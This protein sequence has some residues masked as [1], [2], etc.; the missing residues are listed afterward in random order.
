MKRTIIV[1]TALLTSFSAIKAQEFRI[2]A[3]A[4]ID[5]A[6]LSISGASGGPLKTKSGLTAGLSGE[7]RFSSLFALQLE[8]NY[9]SQGT[10]IVAEDGEEAGSFQLEYLTIPLLAKLYGTPRFSVYAGPQLGILLKAESITSNQED[11]DIKDQLKSTDFYAV[12]GSEY[13]FANGIFISAR[14]HFGLTDIVDSESQ[15]GTLKNR[16]YSVRLGYSVKL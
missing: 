2:G 10:G 12:F 13:R 15:S 14:Y 11:Q 3:S 7:A 8:A 6:R 5:A 4:G 16:Y 1:F 9:S